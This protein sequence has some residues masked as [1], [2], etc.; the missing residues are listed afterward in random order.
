M[1][2][3]H[4]FRKLLLWAGSI[5]LATLLL[6]YLCLLIINRHD[7][8]PTATATKLHDIYAARLTPK[9][10]DNAYVYLMG[11]AASPD[12]TPKEVG[13]RRIADISAALEQPWTEEPNTSEPN[14]FSDYLSTRPQAFTD[15]IES[16]T[17]VDTACAERFLTHETQLPF[18]LQSEHLLLARYLELIKH[19]AMYELLPFDAR[20]PLPPYQAVLQGQRLLLATAW[21]KARQGDAPQL[22]KL[23]DD[24][25]VFWRMSLLNADTILAK[26]VATT[27]INRHFQWGGLALKQ[28]AP[29][30]LALAIP[31]SW[32]QPITQQERA[33]LRTLGGEMA[34]VENLLQQM[35]KGELDWYSSD[36]FVTDDADKS[37][38]REALIFLGRP[39]LQ[40]QAL[41]N[42]QA[43]FLLSLENIF[44]VDAEQLPQAALQAEELETANSTVELEMYNLAGNLMIRDT[45]SS[46][47]TDFFLRVADLEGIRRVSLL[48]V[49]MHSAQIAPDQVPAYLKQAKLRNPISGAPFDWDSDASTLNY[50]GI[51][52]NGHLAIAY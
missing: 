4:R 45:P 21:L 3:A 19:P 10:A 1:K 31:D 6:A 30:R 37:L 27:A 29:E 24:D 22:Q 33:M 48:A 41:A 28:L 8:A 13:L 25:L 11:F 2:L 36:A 18:W 42:R 49:Q 35:K 46:G 16:C 23:L 40:P 39:F 9:T 47:F 12:E 51:S 43:A 50:Q 34:F 20:L 26:M 15:L 17:S 5:A 32:K 14:E 52:K 7:E 44:A 38:G